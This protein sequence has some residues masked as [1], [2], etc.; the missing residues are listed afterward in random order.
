VNPLYINAFINELMDPFH[1]S[2]ETMENE[3]EQRYE[4]I[5]NQFKMG[6]NVPKKEKNSFFSWVNYY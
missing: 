4:Y 1:K 3:N 6:L 5:S 2:I